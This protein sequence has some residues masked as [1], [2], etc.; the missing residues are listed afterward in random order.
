LQKLLK[1]LQRSCATIT[2]VDVQSFD[3]TT[4]LQ[5]SCSLTS[6]IP[7]PNAAAPSQHSKSKPAAVKQEYEDDKNNVPSSEHNISSNQTKH[8]VTSN[9]NSISNS[10][11]FQLQIQH[12][13]MMHLLQHNLLSN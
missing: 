12:Q 8:V 11:Q 10:I 3:T 7:A 2:Y 1:S 5:L 6:I 13:T 9:S 4:T